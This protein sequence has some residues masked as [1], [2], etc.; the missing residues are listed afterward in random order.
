MTSHMNKLAVQ[1]ARPLHPQNMGWLAGLLA[2]AIWSFQAPLSATFATGVRDEEQSHI[3]LAPLVALWLIWIRWPQLRGIRLR[4]NLV[5]SILVASGCVA[6]WYGFH[7]DM[8]I[9]WH[10]GALLALAGVTISVLGVSPVRHVL[11]ALGA[12]LFMLPVPGTIRQAIALP[13]QS[14]ATNVTFNTLDLFGFDV[15]RFGNLLVVNGEHVAVA[16]ACNGMRLVLSLALVV[17]AF[18]FSSPLRPAVRV[19]LLAITPAIA[20]IANFARLVPTSLLYGTTSTETADTFHDV[21]GWLMLPLVLAL[22]AGLLKAARWLELPVDD[23][24]KE[25]QNRARIACRL[26]FGGRSALARHRFAPLLSLALVLLLPRWL[27]HYSADVKY[28]GPEPAVVIAAAERLPFRFGNWSGVSVPAPEP[29]V[30]LLRP[31]VVIARRFTQLDVGMAMTLVI[32]H[33]GD[34]RDMMGHYPPVCYRNAGWVREEVTVRS[35]STALEALPYGSSAVQLQI[36]KTP[37]T[38]ALYEF[39]QV[40]GLGLHSRVRVFNFFILPDGSLAADIGRIA[41]RENLIRRTM[42]QSVGQ[43]Q[44]VVDASADIDTAAAAANEILTGVGEF[45]QALGISAVKADLEK[46]KG[47]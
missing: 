39:S 15:A 43:V 45:F 47:D 31:N 35:E 21:S 40:R 14:M 1:S 32:V 41:R 4:P 26:W 5:G 42:I 24:P 44:I 33:C 38:A 10:G 8:F 17:Y 34:A 22:L 36:N 46:G 6:S 13:L 23:S 11:P 28:A 19:V 37:F 12:L 25:P 2:V 27:V 7:A 18:V 20:L 30:R 3:L 9:A 16:E 29:A